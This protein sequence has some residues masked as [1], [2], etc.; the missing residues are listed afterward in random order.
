M[1]STTTH[2]AGAGTRAIDWRR[3]GLHL[4]VALLVIAAGV[5]WGM[6]APSLAFAQQGG[7]DPFVEAESKFSNFLTRLKFWVWGVSAMGLAFYVIAYG[8]QAL[9]PSWYAS[10]RDFLRTGAILIVVFNVVFA[11]LVGQATAAKGATGSV[12]IVLPYLL[13]R[14]RAT[15]L[16]VAPPEAATDLSDA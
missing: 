7:E 15:H 4:L 5:A 3:I 13:W 16:A 1:H 11:F 10:M 14:L 9:W 12:V 8:G 6:L 2:T